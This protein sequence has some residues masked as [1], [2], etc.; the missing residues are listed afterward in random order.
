MAQMYLE[1]D[2]KKL[3]RASDA[4]S[5]FSS[6]SSYYLF[7]DMEAAK[8]AIMAALIEKDI[9]REKALSIWL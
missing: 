8:V 4:V 1:L 2:P 7:N 9:K 5:K 3:S 6:C